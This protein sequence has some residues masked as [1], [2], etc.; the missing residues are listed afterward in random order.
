MS[1][2]CK[3]KC[4][5]LKNITETLFFFACRRLEHESYRL[6]GI[7]ETEREERYNDV[8]CI[9]TRVMMK[10]SILKTTYVG[11]LLGGE[12]DLG[13]LWT[14]LCGVWISF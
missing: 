12:D 1:F 13:M 6:N 7:D 9:A 3:Q 14:P 11:C 10:F 8:S 4:Q 2:N 5:R